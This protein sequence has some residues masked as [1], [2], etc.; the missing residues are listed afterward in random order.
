MP[1]LSG[2]KVLSTKQ[3]DRN[4]Q[5][6]SIT[7]QGRDALVQLFHENQQCY[8]TFPSKAKLEASQDV[9]SMLAP[10]FMAIKCVIECYYRK[11]TRDTLCAMSPDD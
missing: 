11:F 1:L 8:Q 2:E 6:I 10:A 5:R 3:S 4:R 9:H 7:Q